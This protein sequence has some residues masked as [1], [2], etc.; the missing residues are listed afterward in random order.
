MWLPQESKLKIKNK[1]RE[2]DRQPNPRLLIV[3]VIVR[4]LLSLPLAHDDPPA[5]HRRLKKKKKKKIPRNSFVHTLKTLLPPCKSYRRVHKIM[6]DRAV[7]QI[8][9]Y[10][11]VLFPGRSVPLNNSCYK[12]EP[13]RHACTRVHIPYN[14]LFPLPSPRRPPGTKYFHRSSNSNNTTTPPTHAR[15]YT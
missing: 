10:Q 5:G 12:T 2:R 1:K 15:T 8:E 3:L 13:S 4:Q 14:R 9:N 11:T 6:K 7:F